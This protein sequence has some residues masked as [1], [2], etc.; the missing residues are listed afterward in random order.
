[1]N[2]KQLHVIKKFCK[3]DLTILLII[4]VIFISFL[5][6][7]NDEVHYNS[8]FICS[9]ND[10]YQGD[11]SNALTEINNC[12]DNSIEK[13]YIK[14]LV[15]YSLNNYQESLGNLNIVSQNI[16]AIDTTSN[17]FDVN[18]LG[19]FSNN[20]NYTQS[21]ISAFIIT[22]EIKSECKFYLKDYRGAI[23]DGNIAIDTLAK[24]QK[25]CNS[26]WVIKIY[27]SLN[28]YNAVSNYKLKKYNDALYSLNQIIKY[29]G[30]AYFPKTNLY[31]G[32]I[33]ILNK[34]KDSACINFSKAGELGCE[35]AYPLIK[36]Y[37]N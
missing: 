6:I 31:K 11:Y 16:K 5:A 17:L 28:Y 36:K 19:T 27:S 7:I 18:Y 34:N 15:N 26:D 35:E 9:V 30:E 20:N 29:N 21:I 13:H 8:D 10:Y 4:F 12:D 33:E 23:I 14:G 37:C 25:K 22:H 1:M 3:D 24:Y 2:K 32:L